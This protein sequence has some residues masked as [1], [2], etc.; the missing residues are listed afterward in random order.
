MHSRVSL[1]RPLVALAAASRA[2]R[3]RRRGLARMAR[4]QP[5]R[6]LDRDRPPAASGR[7]SGPPLAWKASGLGRRLLERRRRGRPHLHDGR[8]RRRAVPDRAQRQGRQAVW[9]TPR[10]ARLG[11]TSTGGPRGTPTRRRRPRLRARHRGRPG[12][13]DAGH[14]QGAL[15]RAACPRDFGGHDDVDVEVQR[16][17]ARGRRPRDRH[18]RARATRRSS[19]STRRPARRSGAAPSP[20]SARRAR[21]APATRRS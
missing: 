19:R 9:K 13:L 11:A 5:R 6:A 4:A 10:R 14:R 8:P 17:A 21:T 7:R 12:R 20:T 3:R 15:A 18:A 16:V 2:A 1:S